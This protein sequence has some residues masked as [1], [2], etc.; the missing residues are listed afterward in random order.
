MDSQGKDWT[1]LSRMR[2]MCC[3][4]LGAR[5]V[6][7]WSSSS[8]ERMSTTTWMQKERQ[9]LQAGERNAEAHLI[10]VRLVA[11]HR[12]ARELERLHHEV[13][14]ILEVLLARIGR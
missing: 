11:G 13:K 12:Y 7:P 8:A 9:H 6:C 2:K 3:S 4:G 5:E 1:A 10:H 14:Q